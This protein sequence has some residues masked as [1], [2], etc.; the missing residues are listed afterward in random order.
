MHIN[1]YGSF[2]KCRIMH[3]YSSKILTSSVVRLLIFHNR[4]S[5]IIGQEVSIDDRL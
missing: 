1:S 2:R 4:S 5:K 3:P